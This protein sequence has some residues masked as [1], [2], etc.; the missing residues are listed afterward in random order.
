MK[1]NEG[2]LK[3]LSIDDK[4]TGCYWYR[5]K[6]PMDALRKLGHEVDIISG[7][8]QEVNFGKYNIFSLNRTYSGN[9]ITPIQIAKNNKVKIVYDCD[10]AID[11]IPDH[12]PAKQLV[13]TQLG[14]YFYLLREADLITTTTE[15]LKEHFQKF[16]KKPIEVLPNCI[17]KKEWEK[18]QMDH[19]LRIGFAGSDTHIKDLMIILP[20]II[21][22]QKKYDFE[23][24]LFGLSLQET[25]KEHILYRKSATKNNGIIPL[26][27]TFESL[28]TQIKNFQ[29]IQASPMIHFPK[30]LSF[31]D[32]DIGLCPLEDTEFNEKKSCIKFYEYTMA[33]TYTIASNV[34]PYREEPIDKVNN[35]KEE[36]YEKIENKIKSIQKKE[37]DI[38]EFR[39]RI[40]VLENREISKWITKRE[41]LY[42]SLL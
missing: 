31:L 13:D 22:L 25:F 9:I 32:L 1:E 10:D 29:W 8:K 12:N 19:P 41:E 40:W 21:E 24:F 39:D 20:V 23:F 7:Q 2:K 38:D 36:W 14:N 5:T 34:Y 30:V 28:V 35:T 18:R 17:N 11:L 6:I 15:K 42:K 33:G 27:N 4:Q 16:T 3:I 37:C 26:I